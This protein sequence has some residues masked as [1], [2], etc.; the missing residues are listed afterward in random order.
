MIVSLNLLLLTPCALAAPAADLVDSLPGWDKPLLS[1]TYAGYIEV[2]SKDNA[3][4]MYEHYLFFESEGDPAK[5]PLIMWT[6]GGPGA[7]S[8]FGSFSELGPYYVSD[9]SLNT[10]EYK[11]HG[12]PT[13]FENVN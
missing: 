9:A 8:F 2:G 4:K 1:K 11:L 13:L 6:N 10:E 12:V 7:S 5:D 3:T